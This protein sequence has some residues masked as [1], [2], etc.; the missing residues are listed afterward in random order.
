[1]F[2][3]LFFGAKYFVLLLGTAYAGSQEILQILSI[4]LFI[5]SL[6]FGVAAIL[7]ATNQQTKRSIIQAIAVVINIGLNFLVIE[8]WGI[9]GVAWVFVLTEIVLLLGYTWLVLRYRSATLH[10]PTNA[11]GELG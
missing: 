5:H 8:R 1:M 3:A 10:Q 4:I 9:I 2:I 7:V 11:A 6:T